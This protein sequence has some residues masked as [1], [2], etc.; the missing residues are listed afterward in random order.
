M[1][2]FGIVIAL[3]VTLINISS[4][5]IQT[6]GYAVQPFGIVIAL[7]ATLI[8]ISMSCGKMRLLAMQPM[9]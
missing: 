5:R 1:Q 3:V 6:V 8:N 9:Q 7:V 4:R 2:P